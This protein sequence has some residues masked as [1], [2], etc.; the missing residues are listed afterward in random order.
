M[1]K[2]RAVFLDRDG[3]LSR[4][5]GYPG[6][7]SQVHIYPYVFEAVRKIRAAGLAADWIIGREKRAGRISRDRCSRRSSGHDPL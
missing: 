5:I 2:R 6:H 7:W 4:D 1:R 3:T